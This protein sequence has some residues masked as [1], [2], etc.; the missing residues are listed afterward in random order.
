MRL[1][2]R[3]EDILSFIVRDYIGTAIP[4]SSGRLFTK[5][6]LKASPATIRSIMQELDE[7]GLLYQPHTSAGRAP[8]ENGYRYFVENLMS[9]GQPEAEIRDRLD[10]IIG[11]MEFEMDRAF[12]D[13]SK[14]I[15][16]HL[17][18]FSGIGLLDMEDR[19][20]GKGLPE[21][22]RAPEF[23]EPNLA[24][25][26]AGFVENIEDN[27]TSFAKSSKNELEPSFQIRGFGA[28][29]VF[30]N[31]DEFGRCALFSIGPERMNYEKAAS[32]LKYAAKD[33]KDKKLKIRNKN[34]KR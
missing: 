3:K 32:V 15:A 28:V 18:L 29:S 1:D 16:G 33:I 11:H 27:L 19:I 26:F 7:E 25:E 4:V 23:S 22:F 13:F 31:D 34:A 2:A 8:T 30:F 21:V 17:K 9:L 20:F 5:K 10:K 24:A 12:E 6:A 14:T